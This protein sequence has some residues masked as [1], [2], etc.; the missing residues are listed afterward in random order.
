[1]I[2]LAHRALGLRR[3]TKRE[4][5]GYTEGRTEHPPKDWDVTINVI[6]DRFGGKTNC[7]F[8]MYYDEVDRRFYS[9]DE[10]FDKNYGWDK[11]NY[12]DKLM[13]GRI[14]NYEEVLGSVRSE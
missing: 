3:I 10:E 13:S 8:N 11:K 2:N 5:E 1:L 14:K 9:N 12:T 7:E 4:K 6:K